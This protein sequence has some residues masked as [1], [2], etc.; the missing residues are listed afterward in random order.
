MIV[1][2]ERVDKIRKIMQNRRLPALL[3]T[4][5]PNI[6]YLSGFT[7]SSARLLLTAREA[8]L[9]TDFRYLEQAEQE[10]PCFEIVKLK[11][12]AEPNLFQLV[13]ST[14]KSQGL[15]ALAVEESALTLRE[16]N[17]LQENG[18]GLEIV[19][20]SDV[21]E[22]VRAVKEEQEIELIAAAVRIADRA[23]QESLSYL[24]PGVVEYE[25]AAEL[26]YRLRR[27][28]AAGRAFNTIVAS[29]PRSALPHGVASSRTIGAG[30]L[31][32]VDFGAVYEGYCS[33]MTRTFV[34]GEP[35][36]WQEDLFN[37]VNAARE[38]ALH[39]VKT[40]MQVAEVDAV[41]RQYLKEEGYGDAF[42]HGLGHGV[43]IEV[44]ERPTLSPRGKDVIMENMVFSLEP[45]VYLEGRGGVRIE[46]LVVSR[47]E[48]PEVLTGSK[49]ELRV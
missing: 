47:P 18:A 10:A 14:V 22:E 32:V 24:K 41:A 28:G 30:E 38:Q 12:D 37:L 40:G 25:F 46:D 36:S 3:V 39:S 26:E 1:L 5:P 33:D 35:A 49:I 31:I 9:Y 19:P 7:G 8:L 29:G 15:S 2:K 45:G 6:F 13:V 16:Y 17:R 11:S 44:H 42:G 23:L 4:H 27:A 34:L 20:C 48:G 43:G 21:V